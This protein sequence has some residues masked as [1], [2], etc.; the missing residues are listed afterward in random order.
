MKYALFLGCTI[1]YRLPF[2]EASTRKVLSKLDVETVD[3]PFGC[4]PDPIGIQ[5]IDKIS[6]LALAARNLCIAEEAG[7][8]I[9]TICNGCFETLKVANAELKENRELRETVNSFLADIDKEFKGSSAV[10]HLHQVFYED[11]G[12][13]KISSIVSTPLTLKLATHY[14]CHLLRPEKIL[15][16]DNPDRPR[17]LDELVEALG[18]ETVD[19]SE[20]NL[21]CGAGVRGI[22]AQNSY[23]I[24][25]AKLADIKRFGA[26]GLV[27]TCPTCFLQYDSGQL[28]VQK[29]FKENYQ[30]PVYFYSEL[31][32]LALGIAPAEI[33]LNMHRI[34]LPALT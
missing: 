7:L 34:K 17:S 22:N 20:K 19:Y 25:R 23:A 10:K 14:G 9:I 27:V 13:K 5:S 18:A 1:P 3:L 31:A 32:A 8:D 24:A 29:E 16:V 12:P 6:Y 2:L 11:I 15:H 28:I 4:C 21:C 26:E 33:G 30:L